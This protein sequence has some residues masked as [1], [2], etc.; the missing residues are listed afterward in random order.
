MNLINKNKIL[1][2]IKDSK[3]E[4]DVS[5]GTIVEYRGIYYKNVND[6]SNLT[7]VETKFIGKVVSENYSFDIG[8]IGIYIEP[9]YILNP[10]DKQWNIILNYEPPQKKYFLYPHLL[11]L[12]FAYYH[13]NPLYFLHTIETRKLEDY[14]N[15]TDTFCLEL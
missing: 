4:L 2:L 14:S 3:E 11:M 12:P 1:T 5:V 7:E 10:T 8:Y 6:L 13:F 9:L 15:I